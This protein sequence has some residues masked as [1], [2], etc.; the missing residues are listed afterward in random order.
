MM[1]EGA[2]QRDCEQ[3]TGLELKHS[4]ISVRPLVGALGRSRSNSSAANRSTALYLQGKN[5]GVYDKDLICAQL[6]VVT[7]EVQIDASTA[8][9]S[10][11][12]NSEAGYVL[13]G[14]NKKNDLA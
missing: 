14:S 12:L 7:A 9:F 5:A 6:L 10:R 1:D 13:L 8:I 4:V 2:A 3:L 11:Y